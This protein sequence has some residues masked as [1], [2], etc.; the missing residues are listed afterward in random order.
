L[1]LSFFGYSRP[2]Q[3]KKRV[4]KTQAQDAIKLKADSEKKKR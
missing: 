2:T 1:R 4:N 3:A